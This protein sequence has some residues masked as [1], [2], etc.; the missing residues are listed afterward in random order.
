MDVFAVSLIT[1]TIL[2][3]CGI[4]LFILICAV[5]PKVLHYLHKRRERTY[6]ITA[7]QRINDAEDD[8]NLTCLDLQRKSS[9]SDENRR[10]YIKILERSI[11]TGRSIQDERDNDVI[12]DNP[13]LNSFYLLRRF[14]NQYLSRTRPTTTTT[15][16]TTNIRRCTEL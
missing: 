12:G 10:A 15:T 14:I 5:Q 13:R 8:L 11:R 4:C 3:I 1:V 6:Y 16:T 9:T 2:T 7:L